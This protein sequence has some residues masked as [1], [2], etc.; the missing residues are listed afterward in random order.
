VN[1]TKSSVALDSAQA[2]AWA[3]GQAPFAINSK[4][5]GMWLFIVSDSLT[6]SALLLAYSYLRLANPDWPRPFEMYPGILNA[7]VMT[8]ILL[9]SSLTMVLGVAAAHRGDRSGAVRYI[10]FTAAGGVLFDILHIREWFH[11]FSEGYTPWS[12]PQGV[13]LFGATLFGITGLHMTHVTIGVIYLV[14]MAFGYG[15]GK[16]DD[17]DVEVSGLYWHFVDLVWM[18]V[19]PM[20]YLM[21]I[22]L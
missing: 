16:F 15:K 19:F 2:S 10:L 3:G 12:T 6:F 5:F 17:D 8:V 20:I 18:F 4:K 21:S 7:T 14:I 22:K 11:L 13:P 9:L 1:E